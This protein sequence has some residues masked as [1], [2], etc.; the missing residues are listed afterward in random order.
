M[1][2]IIRECFTQMLSGGVL[3][4]R[5][6]ALVV[7]LF[8]SGCLTPPFESYLGNLYPV[9]NNRSRRDA[10]IRMRNG[11]YVV[12]AVGYAD[13]ADAAKVLAVKNGESALRFYLNDGRIAPFQPDRLL[14]VG[15]TT[16]VRDGGLFKA[17]ITQQ[18]AR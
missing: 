17:Y 18:Y 6:V 9:E 12:S 16:V 15:E 7:V 1:I 10:D 14:I 11:T 4:M 13:T 2:I 3:D 8:F 5:W